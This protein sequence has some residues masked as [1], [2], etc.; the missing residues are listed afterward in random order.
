MAHIENMNDPAWMA[1]W[2]SKYRVSIN[3]LKKI[4]SQNET[5]PYVK[6]NT[7]NA[8]RDLFNKYHFNVEQVNADDF[9]D[10]KTLLILEDRFVVSY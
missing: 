6:I 5:F 4:W 8:T 3:L 9:L 1:Q 7:R 10:P 2:L